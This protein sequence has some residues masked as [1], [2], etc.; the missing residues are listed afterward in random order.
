MIY[1][2]SLILWWTAVHRNYHPA[3]FKQLHFSVHLSASS[4]HLLSWITSTIQEYFRKI[5]EMGN[6]FTHLFHPSNMSLQYC[7]GCSFD[8][9]QIHTNKSQLRRYWTMERTPSRILFQREEIR[10]DNQ[11]EIRIT[12]GL[13]WKETLCAGFTRVSMSIFKSLI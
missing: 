6:S 2:S 8:K 11:K 9:I 7:L 13:S 1:P 3:K 5:E 12:L 4:D 10:G